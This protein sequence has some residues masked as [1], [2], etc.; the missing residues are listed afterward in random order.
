[1]FQFQVKSPKKGRGVK[2]PKPREI[3]SCTPVNKIVYDVKLLI[4]T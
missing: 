2:K 4:K 1:M 3:L